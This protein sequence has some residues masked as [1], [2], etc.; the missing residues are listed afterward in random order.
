MRFLSHTAIH[1]VEN[2]QARSYTFEVAK[3][4]TAGTIALGEKASPSAEIP[5]LSD[6]LAR[7]KFTSVGVAI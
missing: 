4:Q 2:H 7:A 1:G 6:L 5:C 3:P